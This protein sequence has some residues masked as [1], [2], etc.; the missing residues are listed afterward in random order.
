MHGRSRF[1]VGLAISWRVSSKVP[2]RSKITALQVMRANNEIGTLQDIETISGMV[3]A[4]GAFM[5]TD[6]SNNLTTTAPTAGAVLHHGAARVV[7][8]VEMRRS[9]GEP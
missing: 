7:S 8:A 5:H 4:S 9:E 6:A 2:S 3:H 1:L